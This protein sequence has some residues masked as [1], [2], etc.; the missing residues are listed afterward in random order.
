MD[1]HVFLTLP[2]SACGSNQSGPSI[3]HKQILREEEIICTHMTSTSALQ[4]GKEPILFQTWLWQL[5]LVGWQYKNTGKVSEESTPSVSGYCVF[6]LSVFLGCSVILCCW[7]P[8]FRYKNYLALFFHASDL[9]LS[10]ALHI[11]IGVAPSS[12]CALLYGYIN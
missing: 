9:F 1:S 2:V 12:P 4:M 7:L 10:L 6:I 5:P 8:T 11:L 3:E